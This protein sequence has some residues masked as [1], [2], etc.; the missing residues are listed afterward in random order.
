VTAGG[1]SQTQWFLVS[2]SYASGSLTPL[3]FGLGDAEQL[4]EIEVTWP[5]GERQVFHGVPA[6][7]VYRLRRG[8]ELEPVSLPAAPPEIGKGEEP[9]SARRSMI[10][11]ANP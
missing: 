4:D 10:E 1:R 2:P 11:S 6:R 9:L 8:G 3:H 5:E 7:R